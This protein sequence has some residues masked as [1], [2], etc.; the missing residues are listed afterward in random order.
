MVLAKLELPPRA[1]PVMRKAATS[2]GAAPSPAAKMRYAT[3]I[4]TAVASTAR[5]R[6][7]HSGRNPAS[8]TEIRFPTDWQLSSTPDRS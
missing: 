4:H 5:R 8:S 7:S 3:I 6:P 1:T 2:S